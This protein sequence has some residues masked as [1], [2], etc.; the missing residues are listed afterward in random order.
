VLLE[1]LRS[2]AIR[3][4][5]YTELYGRDFRSFQRDLQHLRAIGAE[6]GFEITKVRERE[7]AEL[8]VTDTQLRSLDASPKT[9]ALI[10]TMSGALG[11]PVSQE[12]GKLG[13]VSKDAGFLQLLIPQLIA[14]S[15]IAERYEVLKAAWEAKPR[16]G[17]VTF[18]YDPGKG[19]KTARVVTPYRVLLRSGSAYLVAFD[20]EKEDW[21]MFALDRMS[22]IPKRAGTAQQLPALPACYASSDAIG[23]FKAGKEIAVT[24]EVTPTV[25]ASV[26]S[27]RWQAAQHIERLPGGAARIT[28]QV[29]DMNEVIRWTMGF[30]KEAIV[31]APPSA[32]ERARQTLAE[33]A[34]AYQDAS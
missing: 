6:F 25:A 14:E 33:V 20:E 19:P 18:E 31:V 15:D 16:R 12:L 2:K 10:A 23:F 32:V 29:T 30:G 34:N 21:R 17:K 26:T 13:E 7:R 11:A 9:A 22:S 1:L 27:R 8:K 24:V 28:F 5:N 4:S 3:F